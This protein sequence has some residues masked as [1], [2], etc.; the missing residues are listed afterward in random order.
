[1]QE[2]TRKRGAIGDLFGL[3]YESEEGLARTL[4]EQAAFEATGGDASAFAD[5]VASHASSPLSLKKEK[6]LAGEKDGTPLYKVGS[7]FGDTMSRLGG[8]IKAHPWKSA[9]TGLGLATNI[10]GAVDNDNFLGQAIGI[11]AG[12]AVPKLFGLGL[13]P[14]GTLNAALIGGSLGSLFDTLTNAREKKKEEMARR[15]ASET[16]Y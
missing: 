8:A 2:E 14:Y 10:A 1:M 15:P 9:G 11:A 6:I 7:A 3:L 12:A 4:K 5:W 16:T 13:G